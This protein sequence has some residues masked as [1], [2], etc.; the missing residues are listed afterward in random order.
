[1]F[2]LYPATLLNSLVPGGLLLCFF[3]TIYG[4]AGI[5]YVDS[6][7][8]WKY[9]HIF[10]LS[11]LYAI[12]FLCLIVLSRISNTIFNK[13]TKGRY[14]SLIFNYMRKAFSLLS[15]S[16]ILNINV[17]DT[18]FQ[19]KKKSLIPVFLKY[20]LLCVEFWICFAYIDMM[21]LLVC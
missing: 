19:I 12:Y 1:M 5:I 8:I 11:K 17:W 15:F 20:L 18:L 16:I 3:L 10:S 7:V 2:N 6:Y 13:K 14:P 21:K 9:K 4:F